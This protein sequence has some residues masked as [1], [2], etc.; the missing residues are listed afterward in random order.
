MNFIPHTIVDSFLSN[1]NPIRDWGL[2]LNYTSHPK[3][4]YPGKRT[5]CLSEINPQFHFIFNSKIL[6]LFFTNNRNYQFEA[7]TYFQLVKDVEGKGW[8]HQDPSVITAMVYLS[9]PDPNINRGTSLYRLKPSVFIEHNPG[10]AN[11][12]TLS[13]LSYEHHSK[14][15]LDKEQTKIKENYENSNYD[16]ILDVNDQYNRL[17]CFDSSGDVYHSSNNLNSSLIK[18]RFVL[19]SFISRVGTYEMFP[20]I[21]TKNQSVL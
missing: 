9:N 15:K 4:I 5:K 8:I 1:P 11:D 12:S 21:K 17:F 13:S 6:D 20:I 3:L 7:N 10:P 2:S 14:G 19:I 16:K 18:E